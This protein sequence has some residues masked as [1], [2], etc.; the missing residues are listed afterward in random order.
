MNDLEKLSEKLKE[1]EKKIDEVKNL[2]EKIN[3]FTG[4]R[5][6]IVKEH[7]KIKYE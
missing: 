4:I 7:K 3:F 5:N 2:D 1:L 6:E